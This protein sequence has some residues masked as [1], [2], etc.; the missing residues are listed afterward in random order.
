MCV[1]RKRRFLNSQISLFSF[2]NI[3]YF[4][5]V[6]LLVE[7]RNDWRWAIY[8]SGTNDF[9]FQGQSNSMTLVKKNTFFCMGFK[10]NQGL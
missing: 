7:K 6:S 5:P 2:A 8:V 3:V 4:F 10:R 9:F 1:V